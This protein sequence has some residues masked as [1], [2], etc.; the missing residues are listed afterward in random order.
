MAPL[1]SLLRGLSCLFWGIPVILVASV[2]TA[3]ADTPRPAH[4]WFTLSGF[5]LILYGI[6][7][8]GYF[9]R[10][11][12]IWQSAV[13]RTRLLSLINLS[14]TPFVY[15]WSRFPGERAFQSMVD[16]LVVLVLVFFVELNPLLDRLVAMLPD[17]ALR[18]ETR[19]FTRIGRLFLIP[20]LAATLFYLLLMRVEP[21]HPFLGPIFA[22]MTEGGLWLVLFVLLL[23]IALTMALVWKIKELIFHSVFGS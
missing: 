9:Q 3:K 5:G 21:D 15:W 1:G 20:I 12:R 19:V 22:F 8:L 2:Q 23:P 6:H 7:C 14:L 4:L 13:D 10:Q 11:E 17:E 16:L 18:Q